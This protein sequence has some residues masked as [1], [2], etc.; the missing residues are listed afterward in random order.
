MCGITGIFSFNLVGKFNK[1]HVTNATMAL[2]KRGPDCQDIYLSEW[3]A[4][5]HR[6]LSIIDTRAVANQPMW[7]ES[8]RYCI[9]F[10]GEIFNFQE[11][12]QELLTKGISFFSN[13]DTEVLLKLYIHERKNASINSTAFSHFVFTISR[14]NHSFS[15]VIGMASSHYSTS[16]TMTNSFLVLK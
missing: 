16:S 11:L 8:N 14:K 5:G 9:I 15:R 7:D 6:R 12:K 1:I 13:S 3:V 10:N 4:L 2:E